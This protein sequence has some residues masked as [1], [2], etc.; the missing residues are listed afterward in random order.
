MTTTFNGEPM[1]LDEIASALKSRDVIFNV[2]AQV[3]FDVPS[4][5][6]D[7]LI[8]DTATLLGGVAETTEN[9]HVREGFE[10]IADLLHEHHGDL[11]DYLRES[12]LRRATAYTSLF[13]LGRESESLYES[14]HR[15][16]EKLLKQDPYCEVQALYWQNDF[17]IADGVNTVEDHVSVELQFMGL[18]SGKAA[19]ACGAGERQACRQLLQ[20]Q[21]RFYAEHLSQWV[22]EFCANVA[23]HK[24]KPGH[25]FYAAYAL[26]L[27]GFM[28]EDQ[29]FLNDVRAAL[30]SD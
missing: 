30:V 5:Q 8:A 26:I 23:A 2:F 17:H 18:L 4:E 11:G 15:S 19:A 20:V 22:P 3:F 25:A 12:R 1:T 9:E 27:K 21:R 6:T 14:V 10:L 28:A 16:P 7:K 29:D 24:G 13:I